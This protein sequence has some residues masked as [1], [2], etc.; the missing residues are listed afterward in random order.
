MLGPCMVSRD[1]NTPG[2]RFITLNEGT[3]AWTGAAVGSRVRSMSAQARP[4]LLRG[5]DE[6]QLA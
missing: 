4:M 6:P 3:E 5:V 2:L 1:R